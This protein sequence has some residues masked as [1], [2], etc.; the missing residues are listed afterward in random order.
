VTYLSADSP[1]FVPEAPVVKETRN[2]RIYIIGGLVDHNIFKNLTLNLAKER[3]VST[4]KLPIDKYVRMS[5]TKVLAINHVF[6]L[7]LNASAGV[8]WEESFNRVLPARKVYT[9]STSSDEPDDAEPLPEPAS[10]TK[11]DSTQQL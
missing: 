8:S 11:T 3:K 4:G 10:T 7:M 6:E 9:D 2:D 1:V 5:M